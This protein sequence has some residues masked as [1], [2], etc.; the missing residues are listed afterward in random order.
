MN[1][2]I[3]FLYKA[4]YSS[5]IQP[6]LKDFKNDLKNKKLAIWKMYL[7]FKWKFKRMTSA[8]VNANGRELISRKNNLHILFVKS[9]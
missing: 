5:K 2:K 6:D 8:F 4:I 7:H 9:I 1:E 3:T